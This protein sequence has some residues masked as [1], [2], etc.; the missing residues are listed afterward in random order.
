M[1]TAIFRKYFFVTL[2]ALAAFFMPAPPAF[3]QNSGVQTSFSAD[4]QNR[5]QEKIY[6]HTD[7]SYY[8]CGDILW[9]KA[10]LTNAHN[11]QPVWLSKVVY[12]EV[13]NGQHQ[14]VLQGKIAV[15][16]SGGSGSF[17][18]PFSLPSGNYDVRA[19]TNWMKNLSTDTYFHKM[20]TIVNTTK[21]LDAAGVPAEAAWHAVFFPEGGSLV[22][23]LQSEV[24]FKVTDRANKGVSCSGVIVD[25]S[26]DTLVHFETRRLGMGHFFLR[27]EKNKEYTA[28]ITGADGAVIRQTIPKALEE[29]YVMHVVDMSDNRLKIAVAANQSGAR[30]S[31]QVYLMVHH[32]GHIFVGEEMTVGTDPIVL[33]LNKDRLPEGISQITLF[34]SEKHPQCERLCFKRPRRNMSV[35][36]AADKS[37]YPSRS[38][39]V[40]GLSTADASKNQLAGNLSVAV[41]R[42]DSLHTADIETI[43]SYLWL[44]ADLRGNIEDPGYYF[45]NDD[46]TANEAL[47]N[48]L[49]T[50]GWRK[51]S[52]PPA[53]TAKTRALAFI[54]EHAGHII[55]GRVTLEATKAPAPGILVYLS[56]PGRR[57]QLKGCISDS[58]G[59]VHFDMKD[60]YGPNQIVV[61]TNTGL[62]SLYHLEIFSPFSE[63]DEDQ[64]L[65]ALFVSENDREFLQSAH[66]HMQLQNGFHKGDLQQLQAPMVDSLPF[67]TRPT[68]TYLL[69]NFTRFTTME[70]VLR[71]YV[72]EIGV[73]RKGKNFRLLT[74]N[75]AG[76]AVEV[77]QP[78][79]QPLFN[80][81]PLVLLDGVPVFDMNKIIAYDPLKVKKLEVVG[82]KYFYGPI[83]SYGIASFTT[84]KANLEG[85]TLDPHDLLL[86]YEGLQQQRL[87]YSPD[88][89]SDEALHSRL[90]DFRDVLYWSPEIT[91]T[92]NGRGSFSFY[93]GDAPGSY[94][95]DIQGIDS[96]GEPGSTRLILQVQK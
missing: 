31:G 37:T 3:S 82:A 93:T 90:P 83:I 92:D 80:I 52:Q 89:S 17:F 56:V 88:Y 58:A 43:N 70:E 36:A 54:P 61:Q 11:R 96:L 53:G 7:R 63:A 69:D 21:N 13:L 22:N 14:P 62:D 75:S 47:D 45:D 41:Y 20:I 25:P 16:K 57:I 40:I 72:Y 66:F 24:A 79:E 77:N 8:L 91:T 55:T 23:G 95:V 15:K 18:L 32:A 81:D 4:E 30:L 50:Q 26:N 49:L 38:K 64:A 85:Y 46:T 59:I 67:Y 27:P 1:T 19:Y 39:V 74:F 78:M 71:E 6:V 84:Y 76:A 42:I 48:L 29:G 2:F 44:S 9:F 94:L 87:F 5:L 12:I 34:D 60:F 35:T 51:F 65:P 28:I 86:D 33:F 68:K 10:Y 73:R